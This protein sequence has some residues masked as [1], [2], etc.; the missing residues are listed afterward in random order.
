MSTIQAFSKQLESFMSIQ[1]N[2]C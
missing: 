1:R 2:L